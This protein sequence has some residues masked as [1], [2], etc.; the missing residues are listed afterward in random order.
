MLMKLLSFRSGRSQEKIPFVFLALAV[1]MLVNFIPV[2]LPF[3]RA[4]PVT[5]LG[6]ALPLLACSAY[7]V[8]RPRRFAF[9]LLIWLPWLLWALAYL[10]LADA[11]NAFQR[12]V[13]M[14]TPMVIGVVFSTL[15]MTDELWRLYRRWILIF[16]GVYLL[17]SLLARGSGAAGVITASL[18]A[19]WLA[20]NYGFYRQ[21]RYLLLWGLMALVPVISVTRMGI[22][23]VGITLPATLAPL[24]WLRRVA[25]VVA[26]LFAGLAVFQLPSVQEKMFISGEG[27]LGQAF[28]SGIAMLTGEGMVDSNFRTN[29]REAMARELRSRIGEA[30]W[31]GNGANAVE[32]IT[33][34]YF[35][36]LTHPHNDWLRL[37]HDYGTLGM[38]LF[39]VTL[40]AQAWHAWR[41]SRRLQGEAK[42]MMVAAVSA[43]LPMVMFMLTDNV[44]L[45]V[46]WFGNLHF[47]MLGLAYGAWRVQKRQRV[48]AGSEN[49]P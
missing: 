9:P 15:A 8:L 38:L 33:V 45:Y 11:A 14:L 4:L 19:C 12:T 2:F 47:A 5:F 3:L 7:L 30:Y 13:M 18:L 17:A 26:M 37:Q 34:R 49:T 6:W 44:I 16:I 41:I 31:F 32:S 10:L 27:S 39:A 40:L 35:D 48:Y 28:D 22:L 23:A 42:I 46:A 24:P 25:V 29:A 21:P 36:G 1:G 20:A 43:F